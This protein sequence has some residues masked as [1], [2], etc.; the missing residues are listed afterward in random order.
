MLKNFYLHLLDI[1]TGRVKGIDR[2]ARLKRFIR[3]FVSVPAKW[4]HSARRDVLTLY[5]KR[6]AY[7]ELA[8]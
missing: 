8:G 5:T 7:L 4:T 3:K 6:R 2:R 1:L